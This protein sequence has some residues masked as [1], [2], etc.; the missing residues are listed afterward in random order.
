MSSTPASVCNRSAPWVLTP[1][2]DAAGIDGVLA[3]QLKPTEINSVMTG[4]RE[5]KEDGLGDSGE[6][7]LAGR[8]KLMRSVEL[9]GT[10]VMP[11]VRDML[12]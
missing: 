3:L 1:I 9:Y 10:R 4:N 12:S 11:L 7:Y 2:G 5:W 6:T 8:D